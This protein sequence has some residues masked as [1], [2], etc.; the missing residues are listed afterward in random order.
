MAASPSRSRW[1][2]VNVDIFYCCGHRKTKYFFWCIDSLYIFVLYFPHFPIIIIF[3]P[4]WSFPGYLIVSL[5]A[6]ITGEADGILLTFQFL[7]MRRKNDL[8]WKGMLEEVFDD[9]LRFIFPKADQVFN[10]Q[11]KF[12]FLD[13][14]LNE[15]NPV[16]HRS[17][18]PRFVDKL[19]KVYR[20]DGKEE[21]LLVH[22]EVQG[23]KDKHFRER[24]FQYYYRILDHHRRPVTAIAIFTGSDRKNMPNQ[25][26]Y[27]FL[28]TQLIYKYNTLRIID[29]SDEVLS[30]SDNPFAQ[31][32]LVARKA[33][34]AGKIPERELK[35]QKL[36]LVKTLLAKK[37]RRSKVKTIVAF[38]KSYIVFA[39]P[40]TNLIF[41]QE[42]N[43]IDK[44]KSMGIF[45]QL[46]EIQR[47]EGR[48]KERQKVVKRLLTKTELSMR[49][50]ASV[51]DVSIYYVQKVK[52]GL[53]AS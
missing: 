1:D 15:L 38:L 51:A 29:Y 3:V 7:P 32:M 37:Y 13:K 30:A 23:Y 40:Q 19:V 45:E 39:K 31:V 41:E 28:G 44:A 4:A 53:R 33:L 6:Y 24:M 47:E 11:R 52:K 26:E 14:E 20:Q 35:D 22:I 16:P 49:T 25:Y 43:Q 10:M 50:I 36:L 48:V 9:L 27:S 8:L 46:A 2:L 5:F 21:W 34:L 18:H 42:L 17:A 12:E